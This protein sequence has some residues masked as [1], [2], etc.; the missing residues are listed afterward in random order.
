MISFNK[1]TSESLCHYCCRQGA[2]SACTSSTLNTRCDRCE[3]ATACVL[4][5]K[6]FQM[7]SCPLLV[8]P[9]A[10]LPAGN[11]WGPEAASI[12]Q[13][14]SA[15]RQRKIFQQGSMTQCC[16]F[17]KSLS[18]WGRVLN[19]FAHRRSGKAHLASDPLQNLLCAWQCS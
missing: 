16:S 12:L 17:T 5:I 6:L 10:T 2:V 3:K 14:S 4:Q 7:L 15:P 9:L 13:A 18:P 8:C 11:L 19:D 1:Q